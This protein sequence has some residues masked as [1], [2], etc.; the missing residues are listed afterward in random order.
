MDHSYTV[1]NECYAPNYIS[2]EGTGVST[3]TMKEN[4]YKTNST[5]TNDTTQKAQYVLK[6]KRGNITY[7]SESTDNYSETNTTAEDIT[8]KSVAIDTR[9]TH[10][11]TVGVPG[12]SPYTHTTGVTD[13][14]TPTNT[15]VYVYTFNT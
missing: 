10:S 3:V 14:N 8:I 2:I 4:I 9:Q 12:V 7:F 5:T 1:A 11:H 15:D 13:N 6:S